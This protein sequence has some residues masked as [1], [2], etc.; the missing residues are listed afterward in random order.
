MSAVE[1]YP[2]SHLNGRELA[3]ILASFLAGWLEIPI[4][5]LAE[6]TNENAQRL[7]AFS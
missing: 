6:E 7:F 1:K 4:E 2:T 5:Q 3:K